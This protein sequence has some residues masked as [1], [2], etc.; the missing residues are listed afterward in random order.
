MASQTF[1]TRVKCQLSLAQFNHTCTVFISAEWKNVRVVLLFTCEHEYWLDDHHLQHSPTYE[2]DLSQRKS[3][4]LK[5]V[6]SEW[7]CCT[8]TK[9]ITSQPFPF[10]N[11]LFFFF[12]NSCFNLDLS[13]IHSHVS[14]Y[15]WKGFLLSIHININYQAQ[16]KKGKI[17]FGGENGYMAA[18]HTNS[19]CEDVFIHCGGLLRKN[20]KRIFLV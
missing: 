6:S 3:G 8:A 18:S 16:K 15:S 2:F 10:T 14:H 11:F 20:L 1:I 13:V 9:W 5:L 7:K 4:H 19:L 17:S 12:L